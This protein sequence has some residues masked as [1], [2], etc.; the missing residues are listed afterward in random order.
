ML[1]NQLVS[2]GT[3]ST[4]CGKYQARTQPKIYEGG[5]AGYKK[6]FLKGFSRKPEKI[7]T[8]HAT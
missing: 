2:F 7:V 6:G 1:I 4:H 3:T 8:I 5:G